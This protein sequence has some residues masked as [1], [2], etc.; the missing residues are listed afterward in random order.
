MPAGLLVHP[1]VL[2][3]ALTAILSAYALKKHKRTKTKLEHDRPQ[4]LLRVQTKDTTTAP[5][6]HLSAEFHLASSTKTSQHGCDIDPSA[7]HPYSAAVD[8]LVSRP[9]L[10]FNPSAYPPAPPCTAD[11]PLVLVS[12]K[13]AL[14]EMVQQLKIQPHLAVDTEHNAVRSYLG[15][16]C[17]IQISTGGAPGVF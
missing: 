7:E 15:M 17:L 2:T 10:P 4:R 12:S 13:R 16:T 11:T 14:Q 5:I 9:P 6:D 3:T 1:A 8:Q